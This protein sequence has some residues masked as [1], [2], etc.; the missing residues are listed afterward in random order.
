VAP[1]ALRED[2][3]A[4]FMLLVAMADYDV[5]Q[6][7]QRPTVLAA[8]TTHNDAIFFRLVSLKPK[9]S[10]STMPSSL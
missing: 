3:G 10:N 5:A 8:M 9:N 6:K 1:D 7:Q 2:T 4:T